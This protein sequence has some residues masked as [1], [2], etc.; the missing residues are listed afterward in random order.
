MRLLIDMDGVT[1]DLL[2]PWIQWINENFQDN[3]L[4]RHTLEAAGV[5]PGKLGHF[6]VTDITQ[7]DT[8]KATGL[9]PEV[10][11]FFE[12]PGMFASLE[13][14]PHAVEVLEALHKEGHEIHFVTASSTGHEDKLAWVRKHTPFIMPNRVQF[15]QEKHIV[16]GDVLFD[17]RP[18]TIERASSDRFLDSKKPRP[19]IMDA[20]YNRKVKQLASF[21]VWRVSN[22]YQFHGLVMAWSK[23]N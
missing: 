13:P 21:P 19:V 11:K 9:G 7:W 4:N 10:F 22:W 6:K 14:I 8:G 23:V 15:V 3:Q 16:D 5:H 17:D 2:T 18:D 20:P 12:T 1:A